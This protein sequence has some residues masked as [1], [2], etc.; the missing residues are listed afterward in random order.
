MKPRL[1]ETLRVT[2]SRVLHF[3]VPYFR[4]PRHGRDFAQTSREQLQHLRNLV[5]IYYILYSYYIGVK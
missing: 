5:Y 2:V 1:N 3:P 4:Y